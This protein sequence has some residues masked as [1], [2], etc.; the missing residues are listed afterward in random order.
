VFGFRDEELV[1][2]ADF[3][4]IWRGPNT[5]LM[6]VTGPID[7]ARSEQWQAALQGEYDRGGYPRFAAMEVSGVEPS[8]SMQS[9][10]RTAQWIRG[11]VSRIEQGA[12]LT[13]ARPG[14]HVVSR[15]VLRLVGLETILLVTDAAEFQRVLDGYRAGRKH[16]A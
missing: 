7:D 2:R 13:G 6:Q 3:Y 15:A 11:S 5:V 4:R 10:F 14:V 8:N 16:G 1:S 9:R 12:L